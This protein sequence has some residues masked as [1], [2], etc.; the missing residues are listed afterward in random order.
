MAPYVTAKHALLGFSKAL[1]AEWA[2]DH[3]RVNMVSPGLS[4]TELTQHYHDRIFKLEASRTPLKRIAQPTDIA[5]AV[6]FLLS[7]EA[8]FLTGANL[9]VTGGQVMS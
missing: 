8:S 6:A 2:E 1:A 9:F 7:E 5:N 3:I 4:Q